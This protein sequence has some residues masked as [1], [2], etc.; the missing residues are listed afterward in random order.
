MIHDR[1]H[2]VAALIGYC[3]RN[4]YR[5]SIDG[6]VFG[7]TCTCSSGHPSGF[8]D[9]IVPAFDLV[10][11]EHF[12]FDTSS[13]VLL[14][15]LDRVAYTGESSDRCAYFLSKCPDSEAVI[16]EQNAIA[17]RAS[18]TTTPTT[19]NNS[20]KTTKHKKHMEKIIFSESL[21]NRLEAAKAN[22]SII[23]D[24]ILKERKKKHSE[25]ISSSV[26]NYFDTVLVKS[27]G[28][29]SSLYVSC[30]N[31]ED[32]PRNATHGN[33]QFPYLKENRTRI[34]TW[35]FATLFDEVRKA[36]N[37]MSS[38]DKD[39]EAKLFNECMLIGEKITLSVG[40]T[41]A[42]F[43]RAY[44][45]SNY[46]PFRNDETLSN[47]CMRYD[48]LNTMIG[49]FY[50]FFAGAKILIAQ[51][52]SGYVCGRAILWDGITDEDADGD[53]DVTSFI[54]R[55]YV[56]HSHL[57]R[58]MQQEAMRLGYKYRKTRN[59]YS[60]QTLFTDLK[61]GRN[62]DHDVYKEVPASKWH[63]GGSPYMDTMLNIC[64]DPDSRNLY[65]SNFTMYTR[66]Y[67][68][69]T[70]RGYGEVFAKVCPVCGKIHSNSHVCSDCYDTLYAQDIFGHHT[71]TKFT[72]KDGK[73]YPKSMLSG[74]RLTKLAQLAM[75]IAKIGELNT[76]R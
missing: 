47:S 16:A 31:K 64:Y 70:T 24:I 21:I 66:L 41:V 69:Q 34:G 74:G 28:I 54:D 27:S 45:G 42:D 65:L 49:D 11:H 76:G 57:Y 7:L 19:N 71:L 1:G 14:V 44:L 61:T 55:V 9:T 23:A 6:D 5:Y 2:L 63:R 73:A 15:F 43:R 32:N 53:D 40:D 26:S 12:D 20:S 13:R 72:L 52:A 3:E 10:E 30:C 25:A 38:A 39:Y 48:T 8:Y 22:G 35:D 62:I 58:R 50:H 51:T 60:S 29:P 67:G 18:A 4:N 33:P 36:Y 75:S 68:L 46:L 17:E 59:D 56:T 37:A